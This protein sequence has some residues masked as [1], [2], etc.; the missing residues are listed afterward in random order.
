MALRVVGYVRVST[1]EQLDS[2]AG[3]EAQRAQIRA[4]AA[5]RSWSLI[6][7]R[8]DAASGKSL[9]ARQGLELTLRD[10]EDGAAE[11]LVVAKL[12]R[13]SRS[14][15]DFASLMERSRRKGW[16]LVALDLGVDTTT[17]QGEMVANVMASF[18]QFER[19]LIGQRTREALAVK[20]QQGVRL[21]RPPVLDEGI[22]RRIQR[23]RSRGRSLAAIAADLNRDAVPRAHGGDRWHVSTLQALLQRAPSGRA[24][25]K[26][27][28]QR[29]C[30]PTASGL[31]HR[32]ILA[33]GA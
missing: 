26:P 16:A 3:L 6:G 19:K 12:D 5:Q 15:L 13:L 18:A 8:E 9:S 28:L 23:E 1:E 30:E 32:A 14:L 31:A 29:R 17:P 11:A 33:R 2:G 21:G 7:I 25:R 27:H 24:G 10:L 4:A 22:R 20:R